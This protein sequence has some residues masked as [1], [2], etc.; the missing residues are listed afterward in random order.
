MSAASCLLTR[1]QFRC[2]I[3]KDVF[4]E[5]V[6]LPC[7]HNFCKS[8]ITEHWNT[9]VLCRCPTC[10]EVF[11]MR[12]DLKVNTLFSEITAQFRWSTQRDTSS[13]NSQQQLS[14]PGDVSCD[15]CTGTKLRALKSC[16]VCLASYCEI[17]L[18]PHLTK[19]GLKT[20]QLLDPVENLDSRMC[21]KH[22]KMLEL[23]CKTDEMCVCMICA[24]LEHKPHDVVPLEEEYEGKKAELGR[25]DAEIQQMIQRR[26]MKI[27]EVKRSMEISQ[28]DADREIACGVQV[29]SALK[30]SVERRQ[31]E[32]I[33]SIKE[34]QRKVEKQGEAFIKK[35]ELEI[36]ELKRRSSEVV[37]LTQSEDHLYLVQNFL[38]L[39]VTA[40]HIKDWTG[41]SISP[42]SYEGTVMRAVKQMEESLSD[43]MRALLEVELKRVQQY[44]VDVTVDPDTANNWLVLSDDGKQ[45]RL[46][47]VWRNLPDNPERFDT[48][49]FALGKQSFSSGRF[50]YEVQVKGATEW[51]LGVA[52]ES[53]NRKGQIS[54]S[55]KNGFWTIWLRNENEYRAL[56]YPSVSLPLKSRPDKVGVFVDYKEGLVSFY[57]V[58]AAVLIYSFTGCCF[59]DKLC[60]FFSLCLKDG[61][62]ISAPLIISS[63]AFTE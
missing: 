10:K 41:V 63:F 51:D 4:T 29:F 55:P 56:A 62:K 60:P 2:Y 44:A 61:G 40:P 31:G 32:L 17:H 19:S 53:I 38:T 6:T 46:G 13:I 25:T 48:C 35:L 14:R 24:V 33:E 36:S 1:D 3:C 5:P 58:D 52:R 21:R 12:P 30:D 37:Q 57:D 18:E 47:D 34:K 54:L 27:E 42:T 23:F 28:E 7:G 11:N 26:R 43:Q 39:P 22:D 15:D 59:T 8:C 49:V 16:L 20:H 45:V 50:Y 9:N